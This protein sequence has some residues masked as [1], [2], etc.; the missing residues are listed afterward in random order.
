MR[1]RRPNPGPYSA[2]APA[3]V[4]GERPANGHWETGKAAGGDDPQ[5]QETSHAR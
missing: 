1:C 4:S 5:S 3:T 2:A